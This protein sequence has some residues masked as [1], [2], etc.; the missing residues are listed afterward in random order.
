M[1][2]ELIL[3]LISVFV[4]LA[5]L[6]ILLFQLVCISDLESDHVNAYDSSSRINAFVLVEFIMQGSLTVLY[7]LTWHWFMFLISAPLTYYHIK[8]YMERKHLIYATEIFGSIDKEKNRRI[9]KLGFYLVLLV[10]LI[11]R[12]V[13][14]LVAVLDEPEI[15]EHIS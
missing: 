5:L 15:I 4:V 13:L 8:Q 7:L 3:W 1:A 6:G 9:V 14:T 11:F 2:W 10:I 12:L